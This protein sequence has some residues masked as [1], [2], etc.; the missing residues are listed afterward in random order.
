MGLHL[1]RHL[2]VDRNGNGNEIVSSYRLLPSFVGVMFPSPLDIPAC[3]RCKP[4]PLLN[5][6][7]RGAM[8]DSTYSGS[9][10]GG[11][12]PLSL[13]AILWTK[14]ICLTKLRIFF[15]SESSGRL[16]TNKGSILW[17]PDASRRSLRNIRC[18]E[19]FNNK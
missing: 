4:T 16:F 1:H 11:A 7:K 5:T 9:Q 6:K 14:V 10:A 8:P 18:T 15:N 12:A 19:A 3:G 13:L 2:H 17:R